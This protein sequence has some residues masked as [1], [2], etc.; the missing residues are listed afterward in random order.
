LQI[1]TPQMVYLFDIVKGG[2]ELFEDG[3]LRDLLQDP[4]IMKIT[5]DC[6][7]DSIALFK[8]YN[9]RLEKVYDLQIAFSAYCTQDHGPIPI[10]VSL[11]TMLSKFGDGEF[12][13]LKELVK[14]EMTRDPE[15]WLRRPLNDQMIKYAQQDVSHLFIIYRNLK[16]QLTPTS[17]TQ[18]FYRSSLY[19]RMWAR[20]PAAH[21]CTSQPLTI[22]LYNFHDWDGMLISQ[23]YGRV[24]KCSG[25]SGTTGAGVGA[26]VGASGGSVGAGIGAI[27]GKAVCFS[28]SVFN[29]TAVPK[30]MAAAIAGTPCL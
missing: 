20:R 12:V 30:F 5:H 22:P 1:G 28:Q 9:V 7:N 27:Y 8:E 29:P 3:G 23:F 16:S 13:Q 21:T 17:R 26:G 11:S 15:Y 24:C 19:A 18:I 14:D 2:K 4:C 6:R 10:P 25:E